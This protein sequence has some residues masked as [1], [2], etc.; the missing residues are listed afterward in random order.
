MGLRVGSWWTKI[1]SFATLSCLER[2]VGEFGD[3]GAIVVVLTVP[4][5]EEPAPA[6]FLLIKK[7]DNAIR[8][9]TTSAEG[10]ATTKTLAPD[11][12]APIPEELVAVGADDGDSVGGAG[13]V[14]VA[15]VGVV[16]GEA[17][18]GVPVGEAVVGVP[19]VGDI[20]VI[21]GEAVVGADVGVAVVGVPVVGAGVVG[22]GVVG[23]GVVGAPVGAGVGDAVVGAL[24]DKPTDIKEAIIRMV[25]SAFIVT[26]S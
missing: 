5:P 14:G 16:V 3:S 11:I 26:L 21:V 22:A 10:T 8:P 19:V 20:V 23:A 9:I 15:V 18:V 13:T 1:F 17:V 25:V 6:F 24:V 2:C 12:C 7:T 4:F